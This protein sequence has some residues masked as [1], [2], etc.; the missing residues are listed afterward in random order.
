MR[1]KTGPRPGNLTIDH[2]VDI[3][4]GNLRLKI[5]LMLEKVAELNV[6]DISRIFNI[7]SEF[8]ELL[9]KHRLPPG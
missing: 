6:F 8:K 3:K 2:L 5:A 9:G 1:P 7:K 4:P